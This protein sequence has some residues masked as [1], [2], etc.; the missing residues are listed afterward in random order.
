MDRTTLWRLMI[1]LWLALSLF[2]LG[3]A[4]GFFHDLPVADRGPGNALELVLIYYM[5]VLCFPFGWI[6]WA[7]VALV[8]WIANTKTG[9]PIETSYSW[10]IVEWLIFAALG[11]VQWFVLAPWLWRKWKARRVSAQRSI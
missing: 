6:G 1:G 4:A 8:Q 2:P 5:L 7:V 11:Y 9:H 10:L 3:L